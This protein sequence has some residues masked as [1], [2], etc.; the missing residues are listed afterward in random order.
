MEYIALTGISERVISELRQNRLLTIEIRSP[1]NFLAAL[2]MNVGEML[3]LTHTSAEDLTGGSMGII[4][5]LVRHQVSTHRVM[6]SNEAF[7][8][9]RE[10][11]S[12]RLQLDPKCIARVRKVLNNTIGEV[13]K[14]DAEEIPLYNAR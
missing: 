14:V 4:T 2:R 5:K 3:F 12:L 8:E 10:T 7:Y 11:T 9:E 13:T 1:N 6:Q